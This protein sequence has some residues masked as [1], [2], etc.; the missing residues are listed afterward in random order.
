MRSVEIRRTF[1][2]YFQS[3][4]H[5]LLPS[6]SLVTDDP[7]MLLT[8]AG[9]VQFKPYFL[10][11]DKPPHSRL[12]TLQKCIRTVDIDNIGETDRHTTF[13]EMLGNFSFGDYDKPDV[14]PWAY[15]L[16]TSHYGLDPTR[17]WATVYLD[18][19][20]S[21]GLWQEIGIP[22]SRIQRLGMA[23]NYWSTGGVGPCG[24][25]SEIFYD[26]GEKYGPE[27]GP[28][29]NPERYLEVW[30]LV[31]MR[32]IRGE[33]GT[34]DDFPI[35]GDLPVRCVESG[36]GVDRL[37]VVLQGVDNVHEVDLLAPTLERVQTLTGCDYATGDKRTRASLRV[38]ADHVRAGTLLIGDGVLPSNEG[39]G[40]VLRRLLR[41]AVHR[42]RLLGRATPFL[43]ELASTVV[44]NV[45]EQWPE[46]RT[47]AELVAQAMA[48]EEEAFDRTL[49]QGSR[50]LETTVSRTRSESG[51][52]LPGGT[53]FQLHDTFGFPLDLTMEIAREAGLSVDTERVEELIEEQRRRG[54]SA[55]AT[56]SDSQRRKAYAELL[57][58]HGRTT[59]V[60]Y[61]SLVGDG[62][63]VSVLPGED[64]RV[65]LVLD[66]TPMYAESGGQVGDT[67]LVRTT[68]GSELRVTDT[69][70]GVDGLYVHVAEVVQGEVHPGDSVEVFV[71]GDRRAAT[72][73]S[74]SSTHV[75]H[76]TLRE[77]LGEH[78]RQ[79]GSLVA[80][81]RLRFDFSSFDAVSPEQLA[82]VESVVN[83]RLLADPEVRV[84]EASRSEAQ[85]A[86]AMALFGEK[87]GEVV[88]IVDIGD[89]SRELCGGTHVGHG[90]QA[91]PVRLVSES[92]IGSGLRR[93][94]ALTGLDALRHADHERQL[95]SSVASLLGG[96]RSDQ[97]LD[98]LSERLSAL[99]TAERS[100]RELRERQLVEVA[101][102]LASTA[103][104]GLVVARVAQPL[105]ALRG[106]VDH[107]LRLLPQPGAVL[108]G[109]VGDGKAQLVLGVNTDLTARDLLTEAGRLIGGG[110]GGHGHLAIAGGRKLE[111]LDQAIELATRRIREVL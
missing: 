65:E 74:H 79:H 61:D 35:V 75:L 21:V 88:R 10:G 32:H 52:S 83:A 20:E 64:G 106:L 48:H 3:K 69:R 29:V 9:M 108:L 62:N 22:L 85:A 55:R 70:Y 87:Y 2:S 45:G 42:G 6:S 25:D 82:H 73:R 104:G 58:E 107:V 34:D 95:L 66:R 16:L 99:A 71:D 86:G 19:E 78:V 110:A 15:E 37:A 49:R 17:L 84:W 109:A 77:T 40:Y 56:S 47:N 7:T 51:T 5:R 57:M 105:D 11:E 90:S 41:R 98:R 80:P 67:G 28:A 44:D 103:V 23:D 100:L 14:M 4:G 13:F 76:A 97:V 43:A 89:F 68:D 81:G 53:V 50:L 60:G 18:D 33:G 12:T 111:N 94:E 96:V 26:R 54:Q 59:F 39:R 63:V 38:I 30:N 8:T 24:P 1:L 102:G 27:G 91:G 31:F 93:L 101:R 36:L 92:S 72:A 46:L